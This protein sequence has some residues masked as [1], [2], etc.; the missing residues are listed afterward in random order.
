MPNLEARS[1][2]QERFLLVFVLTCGAGS[3]SQFD[4]VVQKGGPSPDLFLGNP[5]HKV[6]E[7]VVEGRALMV[8]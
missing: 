3:W 7:V 1:L 8:L 6:E 2:V 5:S 4:S